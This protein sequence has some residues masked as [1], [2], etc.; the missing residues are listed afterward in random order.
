MWCGSAVG[1]AGDLP[2]RSHPKTLA[3]D[4]NV[5][6]SLRTNNS[7]TGELND[8]TIKGSLESLPSW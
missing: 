6:F 4:L 3:A 7:R 8:D 2:S 5:S 1:V